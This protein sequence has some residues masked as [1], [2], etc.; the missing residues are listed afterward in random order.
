MTE[1]RPSSELGWAW[2]ALCAAFALHV[3]DEAVND[4]LSVY[5][6][7]V[8]ALRESGTWFPAP[9]FEFREWLTMLIIVVTA[10]FL[11]S[12]FAFHGARWWR[13]LAYAFAIIMLINGIGHTLGTIAGQTV[14]S[15]RF[16]R[17]MPGFYSSPFLLAASVYLL[18][19]L[20]RTRPG[21]AS[22]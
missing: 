21:T 6:H 9:L 16:P 11:L 19:Q 20:A 10:L 12:P 1:P 18:M 8:L 2:L 14:S 13:P 5:N 17:P 15:V 7:T 3:M 4:F 22:Q